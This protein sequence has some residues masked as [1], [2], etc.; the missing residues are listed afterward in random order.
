MSSVVVLGGT[1]QM[2][3]RVVNEL[4]SRGH[5]VTSMS[6]ASGVDVLTG[7]GL[8]EALAGAEIVVDCLNH[9]SVSR[10]RAVAFFADAAERVRSAASNAG[11]GRIVCLS[12]VNVRSAHVRRALG[13]YEGKATQEEIY[14]QGPVPVVI[15]RTT[16]WFS[17]AETFLSQFRLGPLAVVPR[18]RLRPVHPEAAATAVADAVERGPEAHGDMNMPQL[19][20]PEEHDAAEM[21]R[22]YAKVVHPHLRVIGVPAPRRALRT[23][24]LPHGE[25]PVDPRRFTDWLESLAAEHS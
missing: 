24:L 6:R 12:I 18:F 4:R 15:V 21:A 2:G 19:S 5:Q 7:E 11:V 8:G 3:T 1:G 10:R 13:Y 22:Q 20:G 16:A 17:I 23:G 25:I 9:A 14:A